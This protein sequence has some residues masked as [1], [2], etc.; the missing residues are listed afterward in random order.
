MNR[1]YGAVRRST[2]TL[3]D[4]TGTHAH[5][6]RND[7][8]SSGQ[9]SAVYIHLKDREHFFKEGDV[10]DRTADGK[11]HEWVYFLSGWK[12]QREKPSLDWW[13]TDRQTTHP[14]SKYPSC[15]FCNAVCHFTF[16]LCFVQCLLHVSP[17]VISVMWAGM[18]NLFPSS[19]H[20]RHSHCVQEV[21]VLLVLHP[22]REHI[23]VCILHRGFVVQDQAVVLHVRQSSSRKQN[24]YRCVRF[25]HH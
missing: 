2:H 23:F 11:R 20:H 5:D 3:E 24:K 17:H 16:T 19:Y 18:G 22:C 13:V 1:A 7:V 21:I 4:W 12:N 10:R 15:E 8:N 9:D 14:L 6:L 25:S